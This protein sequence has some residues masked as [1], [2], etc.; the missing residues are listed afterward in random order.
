MLTRFV[1]FGCLGILWEVTF[2]AIKGI[3]FKRNFDLRGESSLWMF[4]IYGLV[5][6]IYPIIAHQ[7]VNLSWWWRGIVYMIV[8]YIFEYLFGALLAR[9][10]V[11]AWHYTGKLAV[12]K[13]RLNLAYAPLWFFLGLGIEWLYPW[14]IAAS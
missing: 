10:G 8:I 1:I 13:G 5:G 6:F 11:K 12:F 2:G 9:I 7:T 14:I 3:V 4:P